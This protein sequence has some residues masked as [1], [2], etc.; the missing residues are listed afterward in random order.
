MLKE[1]R[2]NMK[3]LL[4]INWEMEDKSIKMRLE[5]LQI[6]DLCQIAHSMLDLSSRVVDTIIF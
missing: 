3:T 4:N 2:V 1:C 5:H 6:W